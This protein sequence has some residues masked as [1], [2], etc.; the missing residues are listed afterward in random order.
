MTP[1]QV[2]RF[3][4]GKCPDK[5]SGNT[6][7]ETGKIPSPLGGD[8]SGRSSAPDNPSGYPVKTFP[9]PELPEAWAKMGATARNTWVTTQPGLSGIRFKRRTGMFHAEARVVSLGLMIYASGRE[10]L[11]EAIEVREHLRAMAKGYQP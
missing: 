5:W 1:S 11:A 6:P 2:D 8:F 4:S 7:D 3:N 9:V 10:T